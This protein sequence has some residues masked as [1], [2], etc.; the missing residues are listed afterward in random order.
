MCR[1]SWDIVAEK[2]AVDEDCD[3]DE[4]EEAEDEIN[5]CGDGSCMC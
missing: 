2:R 4:D 1:P 3:S 5:T